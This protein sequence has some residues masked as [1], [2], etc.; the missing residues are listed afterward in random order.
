ML[1]LGSGSRLMF[2]GFGALEKRLSWR[3]LLRLGELRGDW[4]T[5][6]TSELPCGHPVWCRF[7]SP[8]RALGS[9]K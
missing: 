4:S 8:A 9:N 2:R 7:G 1:D 3:V 6:V 5:G